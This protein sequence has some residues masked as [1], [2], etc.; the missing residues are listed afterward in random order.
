[1]AFYQQPT[2]D[3][4][5][6]MRALFEQALKIDPN[7]AEAL[8]GDAVTYMNEYISAGRTLKPTMKQK[9]SGKPTEPSSSRRATPWNYSTKAMYLTM[10]G[11]PER[12]APRRRC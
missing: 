5:I 8:G 11:R 3:N 10:T 6:A 4:N 7:D 1:M 12:R 2:K 9:Y